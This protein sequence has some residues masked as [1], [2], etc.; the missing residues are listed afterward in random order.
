MYISISPQKLGANYSTSVADYVSYLEKE[1]ES[2][3]VEAQELFFDENRDDI[4]SNE[5]IKEIDQ[6]TAKLKTTEPRYYA[7]TLNPSQ[8]E[9]THINNDPDKL[10][11]Y[12][13]EVLKDY[14]QCFN[15]E[16]NGRPVS[17]TDIKYY[18]KLEYERTYKSHDKEI[19]ENTPY[20]NQL[21]ALKHQEVKIRNAGNPGDLEQV[22]SQ[23]KQL[24]KEIPHQLD[25]KPIVEGT[26]KP[27]SQ[28]HVH[29]IVS[30]KDK[31]NAFSLSPGSKYKASKVSFQGKE[32]KRGFDRDRF[33]SL[34][35][36]RF[37]TQFQFKRNFTE[38]YHSRKL[39][40]HSPK[41]YYSQLLKLPTSERKLAFQLIQKLA[42]PLADA[43]IKMAVKQLQ[44][45]I[46]IAMKSSSI[47]Y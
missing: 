9:L 2:R 27:G 30:R 38:H 24:I 37:D 15:R 42:P 29:L 14:A 33:F 22:K 3:D 6:N 44:K 20:L 23:I 19:R 43:K 8:R 16:I 12:T 13:R 34:A 40:L 31:S 4:P 28:M 45:F 46:G 11:A 32:V 35:E 18:G 1:N 36:K 47:T 39:L 7:I 41:T 5:V 21:A 10:K 17:A 25:G 26:P